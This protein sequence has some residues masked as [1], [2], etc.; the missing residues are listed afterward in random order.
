MIKGVDHIHG[1]DYVSYNLDEGFVYFNPQSSIH[2]FKNGPLRYMQYTLVLALLRYFRDT[3]DQP[4]FLFNLTANI[5][6]RLD[7]I[8]EHKLTK[9]NALEIAE[10]QNVYAEFLFLYHTMQYEYH[11]MGTTVFEIADSSDRKLLQ[12]MLTL[13]QDACKVQDFFPVKK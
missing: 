6:E 2:G 4:E 9:K 10:L 7:F 12:E 1:Q 3:L 5:I 8:K 11:T 13:L